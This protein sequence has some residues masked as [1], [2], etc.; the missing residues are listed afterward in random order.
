MGRKIFR[1][2]LIT[3]FTV[4][5]YVL[6]LALQ[7]ATN[8]IIATANASGNWTGFESTQAVI[9]SYPL[10]QWFIPGLVGLV[11]TAIVWKSKD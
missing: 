3:G 11:M 4:F 8:E 6:M 5:A 10:W 9:I 2:A 1:I 7:P